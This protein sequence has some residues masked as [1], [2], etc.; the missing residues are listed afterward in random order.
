MA[1]KP[2]DAGVQN[3]QM[4]PIVISLLYKSEYFGWFCIGL[5]ESG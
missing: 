1:F 2:F 4:W 3:L 5:P